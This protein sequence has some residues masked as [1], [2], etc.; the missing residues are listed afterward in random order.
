LYKDIKIQKIKRQD[1]EKFTRFEIKKLRF[2]TKNPCSCLT[3][4][5]NN[6]STTELM[7]LNLYARFRNL[8]FIQIRSDKP[9]QKKQSNLIIDVLDDDFWG[10]KVSV[11]GNTLI[12]TA[13]VLSTLDYVLSNGNAGY[14]FSN[15]FFMYLITVFFLTEFILRIRYAK[16]LG[17]G[18]STWNYVFSFLGIIDLLSL[19]PMVFDLLNLPMFA[20]FGALRILRLWRVVRYIPSFG[21]ISAAF[22]S[23]KEDILT[24]LI[25]IMLLSLTLSSLIFHFESANRENGFK[26]ILEVFIWSI[27]KYTGDYG[28][29]ALNTPVS[30][31]AK[32]VATING[33]LGIALF[34]LPAGLLASAFIAQL[35]EQR[36]KKLILE[37]IGVIRKHFSKMTGGGKHYKYKA[38]PRWASV[39]FLQSKFLLS[40]SELFECVREAKNLRFRALKSDPNSNISDLRIVESF[41]SNCSYGYRKFNNQSKIV[42]INAIGHNERGISHLAYTLANNLN[43]NFIAREFYLSNAL[44]NDIG[45]NS[46]KEYEK[47]VLNEHEDINPILV[48]F[49]EDIDSFRQDTFFVVLSSAASGRKDLIF[50]YGNTPETQDWVQGVT[51]LDSQ[52][53]LE[54]V[55]QEVMSAM[56]EIEYTGPNQITT[57]TSLSVDFNSIGHNKNNSLHRLIRERTGANVISLYV[58]IKILTGPDNLYYSTSIG[59]A[60]IIE[61]LEKKMHPTP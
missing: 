14:I 30:T 43:V 19:I 5:H 39:D 6:P 16:E 38:Q 55:T 7:N 33:L 51:T 27:G 59:L 37:R 31:M 29:I 56:T 42:V 34:A 18:S 53:L 54:E 2:H 47:Y 32:V 40:E 25:G 49:L 23:K 12:V 28:A 35:E 57:K 46:S 3:N 22:N 10:S 8:P 36:K 58:N 20:G 45:G 48:D 61:R 17:F 44:G 4:N 15:V 11:I 9:K 60:K 26:S 24:S 41:Q 50:E 21:A 1:N 52:A 13:I